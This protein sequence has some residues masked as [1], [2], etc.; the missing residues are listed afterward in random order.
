MTIAIGQQL[1]SYEITALLGKGGMGEVYRARDTKLKREVAIKILPES[2]A[3]DP[4]SLARFQREA[5]S[6]AALNHPNIVTIYSV[7]NASGVVFFT[8]ELVEGKP[9]G[10]VIGKGGVPLAR[11]LHLAIPLA[12]A[13][14]AAHQKG[15]T[16]RDLKPANVMVTAEGRVKVLDFGLAKLM[17]LSQVDVGASQLPTGSLTGNGR[18]GGTVA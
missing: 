13:V 3:R 16:H 10:D 1:G 5:Q 2:V 14:S 11:L 6:I 4:D 17:E 18:I 8:M 9:L 12:D 15:I 7:E